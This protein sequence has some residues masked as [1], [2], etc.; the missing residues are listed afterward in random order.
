MLLG[1]LEAPSCVAFTYQ[2]IMQLFWYK[3]EVSKYWKYLDLMRQVII[4]AFV[5]LERI[6]RKQREYGARR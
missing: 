1:R 6:S 4:I 2:L 5:L 3:Y